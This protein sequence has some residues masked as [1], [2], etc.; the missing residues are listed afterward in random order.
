MAADDT[1][2]TA[3]AART[4]VVTGAGRGLGLAAARRIGADGYR[5]VIAELDERTGKQAADDLRADGITADFHPLDVADPHS[6]DALAATLAGDGTTLHGLVNNAGLANAVGGKPFHEIDVEAWDRIMTVN[7]RGPWLVARAL[8]PLMKAGGG[9]IVNLASDAALYGSPRLAHYIASKGA[10]I[11]LTRAM[12]RETGDLGI[13]VNA[14]APGLTEGESS[15][16]IPAERHELY[17]LNRAI[18]R[19]QQPADLV[20]L[21]AFL[22]GDE[23]GYITGQTFAV[24]GGFTMH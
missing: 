20:G 9:R 8:L 22:V 6:V 10:V 17:R 11:S 1:P 15:V 24:N 19:P 12:A 18:S 4:V 13:T 14:V 16:D 23:S 21:I 3:D 2:R 7:A 5:V